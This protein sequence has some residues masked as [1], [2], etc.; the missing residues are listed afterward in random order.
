MHV[1]G[2]YINA[3]VSNKY[4]VKNNHKILKEDEDFLVPSGIR[5][6]I[7]TKIK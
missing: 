2:I 7:L 3:E 5:K 6:K 4:L 1:I